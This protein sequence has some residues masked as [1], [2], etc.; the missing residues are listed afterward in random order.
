M[1]DYERNADVSKTLTEQWKNGELDR[2]KVY[3]Y[4]K[5]LKI[6]KLKSNL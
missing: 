2:N 3:Y 1:T 6:R 4:V 5:D